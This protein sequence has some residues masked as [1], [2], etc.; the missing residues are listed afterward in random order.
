MHVPVC[1]ASPSPSAG[2]G[3]GFLFISFASSLFA[4]FNAHSGVGIHKILRG[5]YPLIV[6][7]DAL[8]GFCDGG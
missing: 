4:V 3:T 6:G 5:V 7:L 8:S 1:G 2:C